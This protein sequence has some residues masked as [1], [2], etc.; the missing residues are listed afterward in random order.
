MKKLPILALV[1]LAQVG[2]AKNPKS[3][4]FD[5]A[6]VNA[7]GKA[8]S[9]DA[10]R[11]KVC[12]VVNVASQCGFTSQYDGLQK[13]YESRKDKGLV[14]LGF[15][16]NDFGGQEP[17]SD[18]EIQNFCKLNYGVNFPIFG[19]VGVKAGAQQ[20]PVYQFLTASG[21]SPSWNFGKYLIDRKGEVIEFYGSSTKPD[22]A[23]FLK[24]VDE[25]LSGKP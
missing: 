4:F 3:S 7:V 5:L 11:G 16:S 25:A 6:A 2:F 20:S 8:Q 12:L 9:L 13:L 14:I 24:A 10:Y 1:L 18:A 19:K 15:P 23:E 17:G 22:S 21:K